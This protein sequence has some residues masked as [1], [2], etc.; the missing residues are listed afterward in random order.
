M[1]YLPLSIPACATFHQWNRSGYRRR[2]KQDRIVSLM[3]H[4]EKIIQEA[5]ERGEF[6]NLS[7]K[8]KPLDLRENPYVPQDWQMAY[9]MLKSSGFA[10]EIVEEDKAIRQAIADLEV[11][12]SRFARRWDVMTRETRASNAP[13]RQEFLRE[14][15]DEVRAINSRIHSFNAIA[16]RAMHRGTLL[17]DAMIRGAEARLPAPD[18]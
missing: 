1:P 8:G 15:R 9:R 17:T 14:Y 2:N 13:A 4:I 5:Q 3:D 11:R 7:G 18:P 10:P 12:L 6:D 16:P